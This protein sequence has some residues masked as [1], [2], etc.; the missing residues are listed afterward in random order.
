MNA[1]TVN[2]ESV[3]RQIGAIAAVCREFGWKEGSLAD[4]LR[5]QLSRCEPVNAT[6]PFDA[7]AAKNGEVVEWQDSPGKWHPVQF[8]GM[9]YNDRA[10]IDIDGRPEYWPI[11]R[12]RMAARPMRTIYL[13]VY[14][15]GG[16][17]ADGYES[18]NMAKGSIHRIGTDIVLKAFPVEVPA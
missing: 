8:V 10:C 2:R 13:N 15:T 1:A 17:L 12:L 6:R 11:G 5:K 14:D 7:E 18:E 16:A 4:W 3:S 9:T